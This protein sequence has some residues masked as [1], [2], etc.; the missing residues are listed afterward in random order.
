MADT[1][2]DEWSILLFSDDDEPPAAP[3]LR[4]HHRTACDAAARAVV[5]RMGIAEEASGE[6][7]LRQGAIVAALE[8]AYAPLLRPREPGGEVFEFKPYQLEIVA[9]KVARELY[10]DMAGVRGGVNAD[11][12]G[13]GKT[14]DTIALTA[15][16]EPSDNG[17]GKV[18]TL[19]ACSNKLLVKQW[20]SAYQKFWPDAR[21]AC[22]LDIAG[23]PKQDQH[24]SA[25]VIIVQ[26]S[27]LKHG[28][29][30]SGRKPG[31]KMVGSPLEA[32]DYSAGAS[33]ASDER[34]ATRKKKK[35]APPPDGDAGKRV[36]T[37]P[38]WILYEVDYVSLTTTKVRLG[39]DGQPVRK[40]WHRFV[41][42]EAHAMRN[43]AGLYDGAILVQATHKWALTATPVHN[44]LNDIRA[45]LQWLGYDKTLLQA[46]DDVFR[47]VNV[48]L[49]GRTLKE[50]SVDSPL[51]PPRV[52]RVEVIPMDS[53]TERMIQALLRNS[54]ASSITMMTLHKIRQASVNPVFVAQKVHSAASKRPV[55]G[56]PTVQEVKAFIEAN[57]RMRILVDPDTGALERVY[58]SNKVDH[59]VTNVM[60]HDRKVIVFVLYLSDMDIIE[61]A[62]TCA[63]VGSRRLDGSCQ[64]LVKQCNLEMFKN[65]PTDRVL[66]MQMK[67]GAEGLDLTEAQDV[68]FLHPDFNPCVMA[69]GAARAHRLGQKG[70]V[71]C[72]TLLSHCHRDLSLNIDSRCQ[73]VS[74]K[75]MAIIDAV[76]DS[77]FEA[78]VRQRIGA[79]DAAQDMAFFAQASGTVGGAAVEGTTLEKK[80]KLKLKLNNKLDKKP[81]SETRDGNPGPAK[82]PKRELQPQQKAPDVRQQ[83]QQKAPDVRQQQQQ[84]APDVR[85]EAAPDG[86]YEEAPD[87]RHEAVPGIVGLHPLLWPPQRLVSAAASQDLHQQPSTD[88]PL[89]ST[90]P[91]SPGTLAASASASASTSTSTSTSSILLSPAEQKKSSPSL[92]ANDDMVDTSSISPNVVLTRAIP[93]SQLLQY[94]IVLAHAAKEAAEL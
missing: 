72:T 10:G 37:V 29:L 43:Q 71:T 57:G 7:A 92:E 9:W 25:D 38:D 34:T 82:K 94:A 73:E 5:G 41:I 58:M 74:V 81:A 93:T 86:L 22:V 4:P 66:L 26:H 47:V 31:T 8:R 21:V 78:R 44:H 39:A 45:L 18:Q 46:D 28:V 68:Y 84:K 67:C 77:S 53:M 90:R 91:M 89:D 63:G 59:L 15:A 30:V 83:Q 51:L 14:L 50:V 76:R 36:R 13:L 23:A 49:M 60:S 19:I 55:H 42:D 48:A 54:S 79:V 17:A 69:Q 88:T 11:E 20:A 52:D 87:V 33:D 65:S 80:V 3:M 24:A 2:L 1:V 16:L 32:N 62:L 6:A 85:Y 35:T 61:Q 27:L 70:V 75:K 40:T 64:D 56:M 12:M